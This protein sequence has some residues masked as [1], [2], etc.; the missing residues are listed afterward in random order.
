[1]GGPS[2]FPP[3]LASITTEG[4]YGPLQW[5]TSEGEDRY[6]RSIYTFAKR[7]APFALY[8]TFDA[9]A[10]E[11]CVTRRDV[12]NTPLQALSLLNDM[13][14]VE[15]AQALGRSIAG[16]KGADEEKAAA[17]IRRCLTRPAEKEEIAMLAEFCSK[18]RGRFA[19]KEL[20]AAKFAGS[21]EGDVVENATWTA[22][23][24]AVMNLDEAVVKP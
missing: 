4:A 9:P 10:G 11:A 8:N 3:Q 22:V 13:V 23:A 7:T 6:R 17:L 14:M 18:Q 20:D 1:M 5:K 15:A 2:V 19:S 16:M 21:S 12:S 24:R